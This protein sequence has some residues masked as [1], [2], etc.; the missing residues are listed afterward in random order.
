MNCYKNKYGCSVPPHACPIKKVALLFE[1]D[2]KLYP[3][4]QHDGWCPLINGG[5]RCTC[6]PTVTLLV[7]TI[8]KKDYV[9]E[10]SAE[11]DVFQQCSR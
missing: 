9:F 11:G 10:L 3:I 8:G 6:N 1:P 4:I 7:E 2:D 5:E